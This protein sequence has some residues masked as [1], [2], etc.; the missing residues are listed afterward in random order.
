MRSGLFG[1]ARA[2]G[3]VKKKEAVTEDNFDAKANLEA[4]VSSVVSSIVRGAPKDPELLKVAED[5]LA[6]FKEKD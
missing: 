4:V 3:R 1:L 5:A 6:R 2:A